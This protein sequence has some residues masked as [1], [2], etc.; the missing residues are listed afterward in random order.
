[1][2]DLLIEKIEEKQ[3]PTVVGLD[4]NLAF[5][6]TIIKEEA[7]ERYGKTIQGAAE[8]FYLFNTKI[9]DGIK[10]LVP[11]VKPQVAMYEQWGTFGMDVYLRTIAY[12]KAKGFIVIGDI[13]RGDIASTATAYSNGHIGQVTIEEEK[14]SVYKEDFITINPYM[15]YD[16]VEPYLE[17]CKNYDKGLFVLVKTSNPYSGQLQ[18]VDLVEGGKLYEKVGALVSEWGEP[19]IGKYGYSSIGGVVGATYPEQ[20]K[21]LR[22]QLPHTFFLVP[23]YGAQGATAK[24]LAGCFDKEGRGAIVNSSR[25][26]IAAYSRPKYK[27]QFKEE[28]FVQA[29]RTAVLDMKKDLEEVLA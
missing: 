14:F 1:M 16:S 9:M 28:E 2:I 19:F 7:Y 24:D 18:D 20:G 8:A 29:A 23:G 10:D 15:G 13:K 4:P 27:E 12:A 6:P 21:K 11:A 26:I 3:N 5:I 22:E 17:D 25:G